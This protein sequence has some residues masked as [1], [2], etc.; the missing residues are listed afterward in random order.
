LTVKFYL[1]CTTT[2]C[3]DSIEGWKQTHRKLYES[4]VALKLS[5]VSNWLKRGIP[6]GR[7]LDLIDAAPPGSKQSV[8]FLIKEIR[9]EVKNGG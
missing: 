4:S 9:E 7:Y 6:E 8:K 2:S 3:D 1:P 5:R